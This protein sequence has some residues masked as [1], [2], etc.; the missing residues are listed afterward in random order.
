MKKV[1][2]PP[3]QVFSRRDLYNERLKKIF[4]ESIEVEVILVS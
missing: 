2:L 4:F 3:G 1:L